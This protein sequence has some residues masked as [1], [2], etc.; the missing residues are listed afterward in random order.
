MQANEITFPSGPSV[1]KVQGD[2]YRFMGPLRQADGREPKCLQTFF[3]DAAMQADLGSRRF[4]SVHGC[5][6]SERLAY[7]ATVV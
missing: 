7:N 4:G 1:F 6:Y 5:E 2:V 3:V